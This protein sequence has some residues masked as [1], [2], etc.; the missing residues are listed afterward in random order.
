M[1]AKKIDDKQKCYHLSF[2]LLGGRDL[3][4]ALQSSLFQKHENLEISQELF[5]FSKVFRE[6]K[7]NCQKKKKRKTAIFLVFNIRRTQFDQSTPVQPVSESR[8]GTLSMTEE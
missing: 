5:F 8:G 4:R 6:R 7:K 3:T 1:L 2:P